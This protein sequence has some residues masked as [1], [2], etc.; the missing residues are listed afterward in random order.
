MKPK[1]SCAS[2]WELNSFY[3]CIIPKQPSRRGYFLENILML[4]LNQ[5]ILPSRHGDLFEKMHGLHLNQSIKRI[6]VQRKEF[7]DLVLGNLDVKG[8]RIALVSKDYVNVRN[9]AV[10]EKESQRV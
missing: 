5:V 3:R 1:S 7:S 4:C 9:E 2:F 6:P 10:V 8:M